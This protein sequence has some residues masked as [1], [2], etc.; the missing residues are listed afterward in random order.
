MLRRRHVYVLNYDLVPLK[1]DEEGLPDGKHNASG[2]P[3]G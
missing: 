2:V 3:G 1:L